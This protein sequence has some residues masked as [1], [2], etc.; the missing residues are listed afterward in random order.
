MPDMKER[1]WKIQCRNEKCKRYFDFYGRLRSTRCI[2]CT[3][4][5]KS[6][7]Y[8]AGEFVTRYPAINDDRGIPS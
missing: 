6:L 3:N 1:L 7:Q 8:R 5:G 4:C 2:P